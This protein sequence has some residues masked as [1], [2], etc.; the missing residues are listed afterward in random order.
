[1]L[2]AAPL[3]LEPTSKWALSYDAEAC[4][5]GRIFGEGDDKIIAQFVRYIPGP[6]F[7]MLVSGKSIAPKGRGF[8]YR[9]APGDEPGEAPNI[10]YG[11]SDNGATT[12]QFSTGLVPHAEYKDMDMAS[13]EERKAAIDRE[14]E[15]A[16]EI[17]SF[18]IVKGVEQPVSLQLGTLEG[19]MRAINTCMDDLVRTWGYDPEVQRTRI[20]GPK[21]SNNPSQWIRSSGYPAG[22]LRK[23]LSGSVRFRLDIDQEGVVTDCI[24]QESYSD[25]IFRDATCKL[26][27]SRASFEPAIGADG[28]PVRSYWGTSV[29]FATARS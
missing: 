23:G 20:S 4:R 19:A 22:A 26:I 18:D 10:L 2:H 7:E 29:V 6:G 17:R 8:D 16:A 25:P 13:P 27:K 14:S 12:W 21:P 9:F 15:R 11:K 28:K 3:E 5:L 24:I 1:M